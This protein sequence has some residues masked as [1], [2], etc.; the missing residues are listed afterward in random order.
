M[1]CGMIADIGA[2]NARFALVSKGAVRGETVLKCADYPGIAEAAR[3]YLERVKPDT[4]PRQGI[5]AIA[6]PVAGDR[7]EMTNHPWHFS[8]ESVRR[9]LGLERLELMNDFKAIALAIPHL[10]PGEVRQK[11]GIAALP[12]AA[13][14]V[15]GPGTGLGV[16]GLI[17][18]GGRYIAVPGEGGHVTMPCKNRREFGLFQTLLQDKYSHVSAERVC[19]GKGLV[20]LYDALRKLDNRTALPDLAPEEIS[21]RG[22]NGDCELCAEALGLFCAFLGRIA[23]NLALTLGAQGGIYIAGGIVPRL[24][25]YFDSSRFREEFEAKG[26]FT[27]YM[28]AIP[29]YVIENEL[30]AF[31]GLCR[32][33]G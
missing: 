29:V 7:F 14:G 24:G 31:A 2:T 5:F 21:A 25:A 8:V 19:S 23:G 11:G 16:A 9:E 15:I 18:H 26:R 4:P 28:K 17:F 30:S 33:I 32:E 6:G 3:A 22:L 20:N 1:T 13:I 10:G 27:D 12:G